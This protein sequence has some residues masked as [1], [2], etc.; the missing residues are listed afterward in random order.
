MRNTLTS[1]GNVMFRGRQGMGHRDYRVFPYPHW[2]IYAGSPR[3]MLSILK[4]SGKRWHRSRRQ[5]GL[6]LFSGLFVMP[7]QS[8]LRTVKACHPLAHLR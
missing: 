5:D 7:P 3:S 6:E 2:A 4:C 1:G 8:L